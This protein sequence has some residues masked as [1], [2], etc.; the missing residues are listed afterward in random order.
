MN[1]FG[2]ETLTTFWEDFSIADR[3]GIKAIKDTYKRAF[4]EWKSNYKYLTE[5][6]LVL[7]WKCWDF[8]DEGNSEYSLLYSNLYYEA[9]D[10]A[11]ENLKGEE[12]KYY[13]QVT[14]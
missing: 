7:N 5:L 12:F 1:R 10:Y 13:F 9:N 6:I 8:Y 2:Y 4:N 11:R 3:F 14:D